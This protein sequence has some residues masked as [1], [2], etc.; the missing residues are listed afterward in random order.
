[1]GIAISAAHSIDLH[2]NPET[3]DIPLATK[4][5]RKRVWWSCFI[6]D[7]LIALGAR[8]P[9]RISENESYVPMLVE[10]DFDIRAVTPDVTDVAKDSVQ[11]GRAS[12]RERV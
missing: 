10:T 4:K 6:R 2:K 3:M 11:I 7:R 8:K 9:S 5:L 1:M 12:C